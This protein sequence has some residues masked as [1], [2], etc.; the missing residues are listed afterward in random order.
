MNDN[1]INYKNSA[2]AAKTPEP[3]LDTIAIQVTN[4]NDYRD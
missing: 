1:N 3:V 2:G 4:P